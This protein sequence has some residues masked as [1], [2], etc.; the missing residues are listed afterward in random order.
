MLQ[1]YQRL[2]VRV[3]LLKAGPIHSASNLQKT[4]H[5]RGEG[6]CVINQARAVRQART[7]CPLLVTW[8]HATSYWLTAC[9][10]LAVVAEMPLPA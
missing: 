3:E 10:L 7:Q 4:P 8:K 6:G 5:E 1:R 9:S 2:T